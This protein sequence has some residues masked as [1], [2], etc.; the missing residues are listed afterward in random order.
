MKAHG[1]NELRDIYRNFFETKG[2]L[3]AASYPLVPDGDKSLLLINSGMAPLKPYFIGA[4]EPPRRRMTTSQKCI[5]T[6][7][8]ENVG[9]TARHG[10]FF[11]MLGNFSFGD[12]F[13]REAILW[14]WEFCIDVLKLP[15]ERL[16]V[17][18]YHEDDE[19]L[20]IWNK[21]VGIEVSRIFKMGKEDNFWEVGLGPCG[22]CSEI[23][24]D[25]GTEY[26]CGRVDCTVGCDCDRYVEFW[27]LVFTQFNKEEDGSYTNLPNPNIDTGMGL[28]RLA[29]MMQDVGSIF[30]V[31]TVKAIRDK[32]CEIAGLAY[33]TSAKADISIRVVTDHVRSVVFMIADGV[34]PSSEGRGY[35]LR[36][37]L[38][39]ATRH[40][41]LLGISRPFLVEVAEVAI[42]QS[43]A[44]YAEL[45]QK[46]EYISNII[47]AE[48]QRFTTTIDQG[49]QILEQQLDKLRREGG[50][51]LPGEAA[52]H[53]YDTYGFPL[54]L[55]IEILEEHGLEVDAA[56]FEEHM[57]E[58][59]DRARAARQ[60]ASNFMG[61]DGSVFD[62][63]DDIA[64]SVFEGYA[65][66][67][68][69]DARV[70][71]IVV[72]EEARQEVREGE[73]ASIVLDRTP[74]YAEAGGQVGD[75]G[76]IRCGQGG[77]A[78]FR[79]ED[80]VRVAGGRLFAHVGVVE[81][82]SIAIG[83]AA[84]ARVSRE[85]RLAICRNHSATHLLH[86]ALRDTLGKHVEQAGSLVTM[87]RLRFDFTHFSSLSRDEIQ[88]VEAAVN[89]QV[90]SA[91]PVSWSV[92]NMEEAR[93]QG[94]MALFGEKY[95][96]TVRV[97][98]MGDSVELC[99][100]CH[101]DNTGQ[102]GLFKIVSEASA[103]AGVRRIEAVTGLGLLAYLGEQE[104]A[105][106]Q[107]SASL[108]TNPTGLVKQAA[109]ASKALREALQLV[110][111]LRTQSQADMLD[112]GAL[113]IEEVGGHKMAS[114]TIENIEDISTL[115]DL[116]DRLKQQHDIVVLAA[117]SG[118]KAGLC[119]M[120]TDAAVR[121]GINAGHI[122]KTAIEILG[123][124]GGGKPTMAM[125]GA[126]DNGKLVEALDVARDTARAMIRT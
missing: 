108:R 39:R 64:P 4:Q 99:G 73:R 14:G 30:D 46:L 122:A 78:I 25:R 115:K 19:A 109:A 103:A 35:V 58:Q 90:L 106:A 125:A 42:A 54:E 96:E 91:L 8:I 49:T 123:G 5:R 43:E 111:Q 60:G 105:I 6:G 52:F 55:T 70:V 97:V 27:N 98:R 120:A 17:S 87:D 119:V 75:T 18:I 66:T 61:A 23:Y 21:E 63:M 94:A 85:M 100:G 67:V 47:A 41:R 117:R 29:M 89:E 51:V 101:C 72:G 110:E 92:T 112:A 88:A 79:V 2:H 71:A 68:V 22:P 13:K 15:K 44:E 107:A 114:A 82:G 7:D 12:Y 31:D 57:E 20:E 56:G 32:V 24:F 69:G 45:G 16:Y 80:T 26:G 118:G 34:L 50:R 84:E 95:G 28:E 76:E 40:G 11:E 48:Q 121:S 59:R 38:R 3:R 65:G 83:E 77:G 113:E 9:K 36:R 81:G 86:K 33:G 116:G 126:P 37:L 1:L 93:A 62:G 74:F 104:Q 10:T 124:R 102:V 53:L